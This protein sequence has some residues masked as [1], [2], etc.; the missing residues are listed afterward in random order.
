MPLQQRTAE[1]LDDAIAGIPSCALDEAG[2]REQRAR[3]AHLAPAVIGLKREVEA[4]SI[5][6]R[7]DF[8]RR[9]LDQALEVERA[10]CPF[11]QFELDE[12]SRRLRI[13]VRERDRLDALDALA[14]AFGVGHRVSDD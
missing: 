3:Y 12:S 9:T 7:E 11:F 1:V 10:C 8:D 2:V 13:T 6:F 5:E 4:V 14:Y